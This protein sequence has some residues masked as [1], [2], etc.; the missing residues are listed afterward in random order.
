MRTKQVFTRLSMEQRP[1]AR[2]PHPRIFWGFFL[3]CCCRW[4]ARKHAVA[5]DM[6][7]GGLVPIAIWSTIGQDKF[8]V[9]LSMPMLVYRGNDRAWI[10]V[11]KYEFDHGPVWRT[12][13][14]LLFLPPVWGNVWAS[15]DPFHSI[16]L[17]SS[18]INAPS[19]TMASNNRLT[20][21]K[22]HITGKKP[23]LPSW[24]HYLQSSP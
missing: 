9:H 2:C 24:L 12:V 16:S 21:I 20:Q 14:P 1:M 10:F 11:D 4:N 18:L 23:L 6:N 19:P 8:V 5:V 3:L 17:L 15:F 13:G 22:D 7:W